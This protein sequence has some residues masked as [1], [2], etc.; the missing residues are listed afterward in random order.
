MICLDTF[1]LHNSCQP[2]LEL[3]EKIRPFQDYKVRKR[4]FR[5]RF[6]DLTLNVLADVEHF[7]SRCIFFC[8]ATTR[9]CKRC[10]SAGAVFH[11]MSSFSYS[12]LC[13][14]S[15]Q[16]YLCSDLRPLFVQHLGSVATAPFS[17]KHISKF[18]AL[19]LF[20]SA[21]I[22]RK[23]RYIPLNGNDESRTLPIMLDEEPAACVLVDLMRCDV[24]VPTQSLKE[25][26]L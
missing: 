26:D 5:S 18:F 1:T 19:T 9:L 17:A 14:V 6:C 25:E 4:I 15:A 3:C 24:D 2:A 12:T 11:R 16:P 10:H 22:F 7:S 23:P 8:Q 13:G 21:P 20:S